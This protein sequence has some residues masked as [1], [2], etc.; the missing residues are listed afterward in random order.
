MTPSL[1]TPEPDAIPDLLACLASSRHRKRRPVSYLAVPGAWGSRSHLCGRPECV[2]NPVW[3]Q[4][5]SYGRVSAGTPV[6]ALSGLLCVL[7]R[8]DRTCDNRPLSGQLVQET[9]P[10]PKRDKIGTEPGHHRAKLGPALAP[11]RQ[12]I[13]PAPCPPT[14]A[15]AACKASCSRPVWRTSQP[16]AWWSYAADVATAGPA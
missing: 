6:L 11:G 3:V 15:N 10:L 12:E 4:Q 5:G 9:I 13:E 8:C 7:T 1:L 2:P 16:G 14:S